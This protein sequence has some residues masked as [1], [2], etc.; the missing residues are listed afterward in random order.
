MNCS[1][2]LPLDDVQPELTRQS[3]LAGIATHFIP[4]SNIDT[5]LHRL[6]S[7]PPNALVSQLATILD[8]FNVDP[9]NGETNAKGPEILSKTALLGERRVVLDYAFGQPSAEAVVSAL[10]E[11][12]SGSQDTQAAKELKSMLGIGQVN[13]TI[14][15][16]AAQTLETLNLKSPRSL[17]VALIAIAEARRLDLDEQ[18][19]FDMRL[20][21]AF[22]DLGIGRDFHTGVLHTLTK[23]PKTGKRREGVAPWDPP[24]LDRVNDEK[25]RTLF[26]GP[27]EK[28]KE[29]GLQMVVPQL[30]G[31]S[32]SASSS[33]GAREQ[34]R[35]RHDALRGLGPL[36]WER[37][38]NPFALP[39]EAECAALVEGSHPASGSTALEAD[40]V[41]GTL[42]NV[43]GGNRPAL[44]LKVRDWLE[45]AHKRAGGKS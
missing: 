41:V 24:S 1:C 35:Q 29:A 25:I 3:S 7:L 6:T 22:C 37:N 30:Q 39:S 5:A 27:V 11:L 38:F 33:K 43:K 17:K 18:F 40:E 28:A 26:F 44:A 12:A 4:S 10:G 45:R 32:P 14:S 19:R 20:A 21:T 23:D 34:D 13:Q 16:F 31:L 15:T 9:F 2:F 36:N 42:V 8:E